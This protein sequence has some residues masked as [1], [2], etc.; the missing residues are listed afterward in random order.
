MFD[1]TEMSG[2]SADPSVP[3][4]EMAAEQPVP[5]VMSKGEVL[6]MGLNQINEGLQM[7][8]SLGNRYDLIATMVGSRTTAQKLRDV[9]RGNTVLYNLVL[10]MVQAKNSRLASDTVKKVVDDLLDT[11]F[12]LSGPFK[13]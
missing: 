7:I 11:L 1:L 9:I 2:Q 12:D 8:S 6:V 4:A 13:G 10:N 3:A 5:V